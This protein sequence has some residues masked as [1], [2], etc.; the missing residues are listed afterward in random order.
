MISKKERKL[1]YI[2]KG[3]DSFID[4]RGKIENYKLPEKVNLIATIS[5]KPNTMRSN[6]YHPIQQQ[7]C[8]LVNGQ[9]ISVYKDLKKKNSVRITQVVNKG[10]L[11][12]TEPLVAHTMVF[13]KNSLFLNLVNGEREHKNY[14][15]THTI[16]IKLVSDEEK[17]Y[18]FNHYKLN[19]RVCESKNLKRIVSLG[20]QPF[21]NNLNKSKK[22][23]KT[24]PLELNLCEKCKNVQLSIIPDFKNLFSKYLYK[25][26]VSKSFSKHFEI[27]ANDYIS[28]FKL[29]K[30][31]SFIIDIG[32]NDGVGLVP[33]KNRGFKKLLGIEPASNLAKESRKKGIKTLNNFLTLKSLKKISKKADLILASNVFAHADHLK[34]MAKCMIKLLRKNGVII[35]E[36]QYFP[37]ML[38]DLTFDNIYHEH[39]NYWSLKSLIYFFSN[40]N[41]KIF[42]CELIDTHGGSLRIYVSKNKNIKIQGSINKQISFEKKLGLSNDVLYKN[43]E[44]KII[45]I[46][47]N[48]SKNLEFLKKKYKRIIGYGAPAKAST[49]LN[50]FGINDNTISNIIDDNHLKVNKY[51]PGTNIKIVSSKSIKKK[52]KCIVVFAWNMFEEIKLKNKDL[53][54]LFINVRDLYDKN[55]IKKFKLNKFT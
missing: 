2:E 55:F 4:Q 31:T 23:Q 35:I 9:Y 47:N 37:F 5:S 30:K 53:S 50:Y 48:I 25:S 20:F 46:K 24:F 1:E 36:V 10:D 16:P 34:E 7:K 43:F 42:K 28:Q 6:H 32:S 27:A 3:R 14:G 52:Q 39:V 13:L 19:C 22:D 54:S 17:N 29:K 26:S 44:F 41:C 49:A 33:F 45:N 18:L 40:I 8:L 15:K 38:K 21:A 12:I 51:I 11:V